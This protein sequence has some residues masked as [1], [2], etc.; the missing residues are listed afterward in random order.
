MNHYIND[1]C[2]VHWI[3]CSQFAQNS[4]SLDP[5]NNIF[6]KLIFNYVNVRC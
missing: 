1:T 2:N 3:F 4:L 6:L 5:I